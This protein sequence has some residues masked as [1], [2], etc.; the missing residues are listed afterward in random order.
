MLTGRQSAGARAA[1]NHQHRASALAR[2]A[3]RHLYDEDR[4][5]ALQYR[6][7]LSHRQPSSLRQSVG[8]PSEKEAATVASQAAGGSGGLAMSARASNGLNLLG[9]VSEKIGKK[10]LTGL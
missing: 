7:R 2:D 4:K 3:N 5:S 9:D 10:I 6:Q 8:L 1:S